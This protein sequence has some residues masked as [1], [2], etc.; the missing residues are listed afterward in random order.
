VPVQL[1]QIADRMDVLRM[2]LAQTSAPQ[3]RAEKRPPL[4]RENGLPK[5]T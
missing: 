2:V 3:V 1:S 4:A 5:R